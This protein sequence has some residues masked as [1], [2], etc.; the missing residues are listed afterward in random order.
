MQRKRPGW[1]AS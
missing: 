1:A